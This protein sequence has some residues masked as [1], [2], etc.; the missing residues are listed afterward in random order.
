M[1]RICKIQGCQR[2][3]H[4]KGFCVAHNN[5]FRRGK[6]L[7]GPIRTFDPERGCVVSGCERKHSHLGYCKAHA[8]NAE[9]KEKKIQLII[10]FG[11]HCADC[12]GKYP[13]CVFDFDN[14]GDPRKHTVVGKLLW[15]SWDRIAEEVSKCDMVCSN[16][17]RI[18][19]QE[20][21]DA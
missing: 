15:A 1:S 16:C 4:S 9:H 7:E 19:T 8:V 2:P 11:G 14:L 6:P 17:H 13:P 18:R 21:L 10:E 3:L 5:R 20:R 12:D